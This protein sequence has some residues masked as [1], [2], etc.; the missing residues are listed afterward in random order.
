MDAAVVDREALAVA[1]AEKVHSLAL[2]F[3]DAVVVDV[4]VLHTHIPALANVHG[5][6]AAFVDLAAHDRKLRAVLRL[7][8]DGAAAVESAGFDGRVGTVFQP[9]NAAHTIAGFLRV[10]GG[11]I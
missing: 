1:G 10:A 11:E 2:S 5:A 7:D 6:V 9:Q 4:T 8:A 3:A